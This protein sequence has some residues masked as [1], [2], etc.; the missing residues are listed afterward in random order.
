M[1]KVQTELWSRKLQRHVAIM[2]AGLCFVREQLSSSRWSANSKA[3]L[4]G[5]IF[6]MNSLW[7]SKL[8]FPGNYN[9]LRGNK[10]AFPGNNNS[11]RG[12]KLAFPGNN[13]SLRGNDE[14]ALSGNI[15][16]CVP[17]QTLHLEFLVISKYYLIRIC[18]NI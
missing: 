4:D 16:E 18:L 14:F 2:A 12:N 6:R 3:F 5:Y 13:N 11:L 15:E 8:A 7:G 1:L 17:Y 10:L 9:S